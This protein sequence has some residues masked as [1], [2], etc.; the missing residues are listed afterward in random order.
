MCI[1]EDVWTFF[2]T[3]RSDR[4]YTGLSLE[5]YILTYIYISTKILQAALL[6]LIFHIPVAAKCPVNAFLMTALCSSV[7][8]VRRV[9]ALMQGCIV[10][11]FSLRFVSSLL[12]AFISKPLNVLDGRLPSWLLRS[13]SVPSL[14]LNLIFSVLIVL[15]FL[16][17]HLFFRAFPVS[18]YWGFT[19]TDGLSSLRSQLHLGRSA[20]FPEAYAEG[21]MCARHV[22]T[23]PLLD[24]HLPRF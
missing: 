22:Q 11:R 8:T 9:M 6:V 21:I 17:L 13:C 3:N 1:D 2:V 15:L 19:C 10:I 12:P 14:S 5:G 16:F 18:L 24:L 20:Q 7:H 4:F 23:L